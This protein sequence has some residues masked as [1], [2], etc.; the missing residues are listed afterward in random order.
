MIC[1]PHHQN[2]PCRGSSIGRACGSYNSERSTSR[3]WVRAPP[4]AIPISKSH[5][6]SCSFAFCIV[7]TE[8]SFL[9]V[10]KPLHQ[11][12]VSVVN[13]LCALVS[14]HSLLVSRLILIEGLIVPLVR[15]KA[16]TTRPFES[17]SLAR[18]YMTAGQ[19]VRSLHKSES[20]GSSLAIAIDD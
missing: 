14:S 12:V 11:L 1:P 19:S 3:S 18:I 7:D 8:L 16:F 5:L 2:N 9:L 15:Q 10:A 6:G 20:Y 4:S 13:L 17:P